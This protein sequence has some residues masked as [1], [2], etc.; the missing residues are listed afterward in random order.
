MYENEF[1]TYSCLTSLYFSIPLVSSG[2]VDL[3]GEI[4]KVF[5]AVNI[6][7]EASQLLEYF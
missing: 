7:A 1:S 2:K 4:L 3:S 6:F 5:A